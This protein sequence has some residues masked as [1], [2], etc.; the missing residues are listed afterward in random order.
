MDE[1]EWPELSGPSKL[2]EQMDRAGSAVPER[3]PTRKAATPPLANGTAAEVVAAGPSMARAASAPNAGNAAAADG[4]RRAAN[5]A[6]S[7]KSILGRKPSGKGLASRQKEKEQTPVAAPS[8]PAPAAPA[9]ATPSPT[10]EVAAAPSAAEQQSAAASVE[11]P[12]RVSKTGPVEV[13]KEGSGEGVTPEKQKVEGKAEEVVEVGGERGVGAV[14]AAVNA[15]PGAAK[16]SDRVDEVSASR[17]RALKS[18]P[19]GFSAPACA[20]PVPVLPALTKK[21]RALSTSS[22]APL[23][24]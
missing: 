2:A 8:D 1:T 22:L 4:T 5:G 24:F 11:S 23:E 13:L 7:G 9:A 18:P 21:V 14:E 6:L 10:P 3:G 12:S 19:P 20:S 17:A 16:A 15:A